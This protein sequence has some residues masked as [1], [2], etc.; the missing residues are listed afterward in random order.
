[1]CV[2]PP[3]VEVL[4]AQVVVRYQG[5]K[6]SYIEAIESCSDSY[7]LTVLPDSTQFLH[8]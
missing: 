5:E 2:K 6:L 8:I 3:Y 1:M 7:R 4:G